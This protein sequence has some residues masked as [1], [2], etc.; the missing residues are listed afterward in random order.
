MIGAK[1]GLLSVVPVAEDLLDG[2]Q[3]QGL[4][5]ERLPPGMADQEAGIKQ[6]GRV[7]HRT[8]AG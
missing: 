5:V 4:G 6:A 2:H 8:H 7:A 1:G 3:T